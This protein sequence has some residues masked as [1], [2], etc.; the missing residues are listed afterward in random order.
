MNL[1]DPLEG[2]VR[3]MDGRV[4]QALARAVDGLTGRRIE[5]VIGSRSRSGIV[6]S[7]DRL[8]RIG[9]VGRSEV[10]NSALYSL[11]R[12]HVMWAPLFEIL[13][14][15]VALQTGLAELVEEIFPQSPP[16]ATALYG[17]VARGTST[18][19][20]DIDIVM[21]F[22]SGSR[23]SERATGVEGIERALTERFGN[24][25]E[26]LDLDLDQLGDLVRSGDPLA[27]ALLDDAVTVAGPNVKQLIR[28]VP[29]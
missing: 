9:L 23:A 6:A 25:A 7:L 11:N 15:R 2:L 10:G 3:P 19:D 17:S 16:P 27:D 8:V 18:L 21:I 14:A 20:S 29:R 12:D 22:P 28:N 13:G 5:H 24:R 1:S 26:I 4:L